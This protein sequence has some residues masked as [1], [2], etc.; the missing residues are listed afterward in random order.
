MIDIMRNSDLRFAIFM[1]VM[2]IYFSIS[3]KTKSTK[4]EMIEYMILSMVMF[5]AEM[6]Y[7]GLNIALMKIEMQDWILIHLR[8]IIEASFA[9]FFAYQLGKK[10][11]KEEGKEEYREKRRRWIVNRDEELKKIAEKRKK[12]SI[13]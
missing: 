8:V 11:G 10:R 12:K 3:H 4:I 7:Y 2:I 6:Y 1:C 13:K 9:L 5:G